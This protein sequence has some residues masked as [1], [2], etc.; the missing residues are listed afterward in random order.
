[1]DKIITEANFKEAFLAY[2]FDDVK[3]CERYGSGHINDTFLLIE[4]SGDKV[5]LQRMNTLVFKDPEMLMEN[6]LLVTDFLKTSIEKEG[7]DPK[8]ETM[9]VRLTKDKKPFFKDAD[10]NY[11]RVYEFID[12]AT[13]YDSVKRPKDFYESAYAFGKFQ[14][15]LASFDASKLGE[16]IKDFHNTPKR[17]E[18]FLQVVKEDVKGRAK[19]C[20]KEI[21]FVNA[22]AKAM[23]E[24]TDMLKNGE[25]P[26]RVTHN[27]TKLNNVLIDDATGMGLCVID[28]DTVMPGLSIN[29]FGD[30][31]R[32]G[33]NTAV[34]DE[35]DV[36]KV[37]LSLELFECYAEG[38]LKGCGGKLTD[39]EL[40]MLPV[41]A[42]LMTLE[43][44]MRFLTDYLEGD[45]YFNTKYD[46]HNLVRC[47][48]QFAL[49]KDI[50]DKM[51]KCHEIIKKVSNH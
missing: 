51:D 43:C 32:F 22:R 8:R 45:V 21:D 35:P 4:N 44:G 19:T 17:Y 20:Q 2:G 49:V 9:S 6:V 47:R 41:G 39:N 38:F 50:E 16:V 10:D 37:S 46:D 24:A 15:Y 25:L 12:K 13:G 26:L 23:S 11:W 14:K 18:R 48:T 3:S 33:A 31:I 7:G 40:K 28:L 27:D 30:S 36:S 34:E 42:K 5:I 1:M 29:D